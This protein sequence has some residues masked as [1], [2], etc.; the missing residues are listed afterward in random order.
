[1]FTSEG[2]LI[3][4]WIQAAVYRDGS[5]S[6]RAYADSAVVIKKCQRKGCSCQWWKMARGVCWTATAFHPATRFILSHHPFIQLTGFSV[7]LILLT[8]TSA[9]R[10]QSLRLWVL[11]WNPD[12]A[13]LKFSVLCFVVFFFFLLLFFF[14]LFS[15]SGRMVAQCSHWLLSWIFPRRPKQQESC[16]RHIVNMSHKFFFSVF[17]CCRSRRAPCQRGSLHWHRCSPLRCLG[18][19]QSP[20]RCCP[21]T[22]W[23]ERILPLSETWGRARFVGMKPLACT[24]ELWSAYPARWECLFKVPAW[25]TFLEW[26]EVYIGWVTGFLDSC[27]DMS[28]IQPNCNASD[29]GTE[30]DTTSYFQMCEKGLWDAD[31]N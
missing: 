17:L 31:R 3:V 26:Q 16:S 13:I 21:W 2:Q 10:F 19:R 23:L 1:M 8:I 20:P 29:T 18:L 30:I 4:Y 15:S 12:F 22:V 11:W 5:K 25:T 28:I 27:E 7:S 9:A 6:K 24:S 14:F